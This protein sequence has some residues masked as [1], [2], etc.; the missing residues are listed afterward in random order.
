MPAGGSVA[1]NSACQPHKDPV[2]VSSPSGMAFQG[3]DFLHLLL[4]NLY[5]I[6]KVFAITGATRV[7]A[8]KPGAQDPE[9]P[10]GQGASARSPPD[11]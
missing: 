9:N 4:Q 2:A 1:V 11:D 10:V 7:Q 6:K 8:D 5:L 3:E